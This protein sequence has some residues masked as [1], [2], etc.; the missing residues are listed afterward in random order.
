MYPYV[1]V[2]QAGFSQCASEACHFLLGLPGLDAGVGRRLVAHL[3]QVVTEL[4]PSLAANLAANRAANIG[5]VRPTAYSPPASPDLLLARQHQAQDPSLIASTS[6]SRSSPRSP[7]GPASPEVSSTSSAGWAGA[8]AAAR[9]VKRPLERSEAED[10]DDDLDSDSPVNYATD[11]LSKQQAK[12]P[13]FDYSDPTGRA[14]Q[15]AEQSNEQPYGQTH[16][17]STSGAMGYDMSCAMSSARSYVS[18][19]AASQSGSDD[20]DKGPMWRPW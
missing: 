13:R 17:S 4:G 3:S 6:S 1:P 16:C 2:L 11:A 10:S 20:E 7:S 5:S 14:V 8:G 15:P 12:R 19:S 18:S 9:P